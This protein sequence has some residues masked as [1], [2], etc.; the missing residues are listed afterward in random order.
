MSKLLFLLFAHRKN[1][2]LLTYVFSTLARSMFQHVTGNGI[3]VC[4][5]VLKSEF[6]VSTAFKHLSKDCSL[7]IKRIETPALQL[8]DVFNHESHEHQNRFW[9]NTSS[10]CRWGGDPRGN[11]RMHIVCSVVVQILS[12]CLQP[13]PP[14]PPMAETYGSERS[15]RCNPHSLI[16]HQS[17]RKA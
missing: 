12:M 9:S 11:A 13:A 15:K 1:E 17:H 5:C 3:I 7:Y 2:W 6:P 10:P 4:L 16:T 14:T 8:S